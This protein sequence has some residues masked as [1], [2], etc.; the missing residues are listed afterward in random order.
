MQKRSRTIVAI[1]LG[2]LFCWLVWKIVSPS[3]PAYQGRRLTLWLEQYRKFFVARDADGRKQRDEA[4]KAL[5]E[6][7]TNGLPSLLAMVGKR[8]SP[9]KRKLTTWAS[10]QK[11]VPI[12]LPTPDDYHSLASFGFAALR[13]TAKPAVPSLIVLLKDRDA[14]VQAC[15]A[16]CLAPI[17]PDAEEAVPALV[18]SLTNRNNGKLQLDSM[19]ALG[20]ISRKPAIA[21]PVLMEYLN[22]SRSDWG[23]FRPAIRALGF[24]GKE[25]M[26]A[27]PAIQP[28]LNEANPSMQ[29]EARSALWRITGKWPEERSR[30]TSS[31]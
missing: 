27:V 31:P 16:N 26:V 30:Q 15:A 14:D 1:L 25:A 10:K 17:G 7:G 11:L 4:E 23:Y 20:S 24:Y 29:S 6:I 19:M 3:E 2:I 22:G 28:F 8:D 21:I 5:R 18:Q 13:S 12:R 9:L